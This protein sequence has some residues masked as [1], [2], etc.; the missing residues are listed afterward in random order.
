MNTKFYSPLKSMLLLG[1]FLLSTFLTFAQDRRVT[2]NVTG[3]DGGT[4]P[5]ASIKIKGTNS[6]TTTNGTGDFALNVKSAN[7][8]LVVS[9]VGYKTLEV[10]VGTRSVVNISLQSDVSALDEVV[11]TGYQ[12]LRKRDI[13]GA[14]TIIETE[15]LK[16][17][18][19]SSFTQNLA[20]RASGV[21]ISSSG[22]PGD[23]TNV[24]IRGISSFTSNDPLYIIDGVPV[25]DQ[26][27]NLINPDDI[28][29]IQVLKDASTAS[30]Y[31]S[32]ASNGVIV[33]T[34]KQGKSGKT[35][36]TYNGSFGLATSV[37]G[38]NEVLNQSS[39]DWA[40]ALKLKFPTDTP[41]PDP[42]NL[43]KYVNP[44]SNTV[45]E[46]TYDA[47]NNQ[48]SLTSA[49][50][51]WWKEST[52]TAQIHDHNIS[53]SGGNDHAT[54][55]ITASYL[56]Q[57]GIFNYTDYNRA[58]IRAN[59]QYKV[60][61]A[62]R[63]GENMTYASNWGVN[64]G[65][66]GG[67]NNEQ[68]IIGNIL[69]STPIVPLYDIKGNPGGHTF[70][71]L[72]GNFTNPTQKLINAKDN[73]NKYNRLLGNIYAEVDV[74]KGLTL[75]SSFGVDVGT[76]FYKNFTYPEP[77]R[78]EGNKTANNFTENWSQSFTYSWTNTANYSQD[79]G[80]HHVGVLVG[81]EAVASTYRSINSN[82][83]GYFTTDVNAWYINTAFG[84]PSSL[85]TNSTGN[86]SKLA[87]YFGKVDYAFNDRYLLSATIRRDGSS[88][89]LSDVR[90]GIFPAVSVGWRVSQEGFMKE[91][92]WISDLK[93]RASYGEVGN[94]DIRNYNF[95][96]LYGGS[97]GSTFY[98]INGSNGNVATGYAL[99]E[100]GNAST[101]W[102]SAKTTNFGIDGAF[103]NN[104][105]TVVLDIYKRNTDNLLY[106]PALPGTA[107][108]AVAPY[109]N[110]GAMEN[111]GFDLGL[112]Y[113]KSV[114][115]DLSF[116]V[117]LN[118]SRYKNTIVKVANNDD[119][120]IPSDG[121]DGRLDISAYVN[122]VGYSISSFRGF[123]V[124][125]LITTEAERANQLAGAVIGGLKYK[126]TNGDGKITD[127]DRTVI[128]SPHP[129]LT[130]GLNLGANYKGFDLTAFMFGSFGNDIFNYTK[131][132]S[133]FM[134]F[135][136]NI[137]INT[138]ALQGTGNNP[139]INGSDLASRAS[140]T[141]YIENGSYVRLANLQL[142]YR[143]PK[144]LASKIGVG[145]A[146]VYIQGQNLLTFTGYSGVD[147]AVSSANIGGGS[148]VNDVGKSGFDGGHY[149]ANK[150]TTIGLSLE[151]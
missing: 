102:E 69:K 5:G 148:N 131:M 21:T 10:S 41:F 79:F 93:L 129:S 75:R 150:I 7:D 3:S 86:E 51:D 92:P 114:N 146:R 85:N 140:S 16:S 121:L 84:N 95:S 122:K 15:G 82:L 108:S 112:T 74:I 130:A 1:V 58:T 45:D 19:G 134:N 149:P 49:G 50:T 89:F 18:K 127:A 55:S 12:T 99:R 116:N 126:D 107:G 125:S 117:G 67:G 76:G 118:L 98:D 6:G 90:Y 65:S 17:V 4:I 61:K 30:I 73:T 13:T 54:F 136:S 100:R 110:I 46:G 77:Y 115:K 23:A 22:S 35:K 137:G 119:Q 36:V 63:I 66:S 27:Q 37:K 38:Y 94:Q 97:V 47:I 141:F 57:E 124:E 139:K 60:T 132:F 53:L 59:S 151:F 9:S 8:V 145:G 71:A 14:V 34:T 40:T 106:N 109:V 33:I 31:G 62:F 120:F 96:N 83:A 26:Y 28:E 123:V 142:G 138:L 78:V 43:P 80:K 101:I 24:R 87:S 104:A 72:T 2:G 147:P 81:Q 52:R 143:L 39:K 29:S 91:L 11:V 103:L 44:I 68:G 105:L 20:G 135:N 128:G 144:D 56:N 111:T 42:S 48:I 113:R 88:K 70:T 32:R 133:Y 64:I 25:K